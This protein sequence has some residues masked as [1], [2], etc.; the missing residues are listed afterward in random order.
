[1]FSWAPVRERL[2]GRHCAARWRVVT[3]A[4]LLLLPTMDDDQRRRQT[5]RPHV[6]AS[7]P[8]IPRAERRASTPAP[9][10]R[11]AAYAVTCPHHGGCNVE[12]NLS[13][14]GLFFSVDP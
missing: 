3:M 1:M 4:E 8:P 9:T 5:T 13:A 12:V 14:L 7:L 2:S 10:W 6:Q 11:K